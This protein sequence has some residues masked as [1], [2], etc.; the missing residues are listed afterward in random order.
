MHDHYRQVTFILNREMAIDCVLTLIF[1]F[2]HPSTVKELCLLY[3][4]TAEDAVA[5]WIAFSTTH[6]GLAINMDTLEQLEREVR[7]PEEGFDA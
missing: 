1:S 4:L 6:S 2:P 3:R 5:E 7:M